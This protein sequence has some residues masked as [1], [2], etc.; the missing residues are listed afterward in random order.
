MLQVAGRAFFNVHVR[1]CDAIDVHDVLVS[2]HNHVGDSGVA[3]R[4]VLVLDH[5]GSL[6]SFVCRNKVEGVASEEGFWAVSVVGP[7][8]VGNVERF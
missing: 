7:L 5:L 3:E 2:G 6:V 4:N 1:V 8:A